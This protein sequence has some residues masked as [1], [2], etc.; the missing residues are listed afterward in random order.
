MTWNTNQEVK[1]LA[2]ISL[3]HI[4][5]LSWIMQNS[6]KNGRFKRLLET[7]FGMVS[8]LRVSIDAARRLQLEKQGIGA[9]LRRVTKERVC[10][11]IE[12]LGCLQID[13]INIVERA[14]YFTLWT[15][16]GQYRK[17]DLYKLAYEN[18]RLFEGW[19][20]AMCYMPMRDWRYMIAANKQRA[21]D[22]VIHKG[23]FSRV[24][25]DIVDAVRKRIKTEGPLSSVNFEGNKPSS[26]WWGWKPAKRGLEALFSAGEL[27]VVRRDGFQRVYDLTERVLPSWVEISEPSEEERVKFFATRT[28]GCLGATKPADIRSYYYNWCIKLDRTV[29][30]LQVL[31]DGMVEEGVVT[32]L[33]VDGLRSPHYCLAED[34]PRLE[35]FEDDWG[36]GNVRFVNYFDSLLWHKDRVES[37]FGFERALE[38]YLKPKDRRF[39]YFTVPILYGDKLVGRFYPKL[40][41]KEKKFIIRGLWFE[42]GFKPDEQFEDEF[43]KALYDFALF[44]R[45]EN[46]EWRLEKAPISG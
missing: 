22:A 7:V 1:P 38:V 33:S 36:C 34:A 23:W 26:G 45:A 20:H 14:H 15:R 25:P 39:G 16:L 41:R 35:K 40:E 4:A 8:A 18:R 9:P 42:E 3:I 2:D 10:E 29:K 30:Q 13:T 28:L 32:K 6:V 44:N 17:E 37:L 31:L 5:T 19:G 27:M 21:K 43:K 46:V 12:R 24:E 11:T